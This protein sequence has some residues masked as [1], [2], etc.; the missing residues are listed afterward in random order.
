MELAETLLQVAYV[1][2]V[3]ADH[4]LSWRAFIWT[5]PIDD[6]RGLEIVDVTPPADAIGPKV[7]RTRKA[8]AES[9]SS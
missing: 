7:R 5:V 8:K 1:A 3:R 9:A 4:A 2:A 6:F